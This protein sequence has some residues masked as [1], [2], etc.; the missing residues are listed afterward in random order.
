MANLSRSEVVIVLNYFGYEINPYYKFKIRDERTP[1]VS[2]AENGY[3]KDFGSDWGGDIYNFLKDFHNLNFTDANK[4]ISDILGYQKD[5]NFINTT[6]NPKNNISYI[7]QDIIDKFKVD[8]QQNFGE[9]YKILEKAMPCISK[10]KRLEFAEKYEIGYISQSKRIVMPIRDENGKCM[11]LWKYSPYP[12]EVLDKEGKATILPKVLFSKG[13]RR[14]PFNLNDLNNFRKELDK[15]IFL[16]EGEKDCLNA[17]A[18]GFRSVT[19]GSASARLENN[20][21]YLF[22]NLNIVIAYDYDDTGK[23]GARELKE[24]LKDICK[25]IEIIE[26]DKILHNIGKSEYLKKGFDFTDFIKATKEKSI[27]K[28]KSS[29]VDREI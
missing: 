28:E 6:S 19:L 13:R 1:S 17:L 3:I 24:Q 12:Q 2:I 7:T 11:T 25:S 20:Q 14:C 27:E 10:Q 29:L 4:K 22:K 8:R 21:I 15:Q 9:F 5:P 16:V 23:K 26:W 18:N